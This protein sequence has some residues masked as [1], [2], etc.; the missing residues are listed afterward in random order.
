[1]N[2]RNDAARLIDEDD[3]ARCGYCG[4]HAD[5]HTYGTPEGAKRG[6][7]PCVGCTGGIC[8]RPAASAA[9]ADTVD[10]ADHAEGAARGAIRCGTGVPLEL[11]EPGD[12]A[13][14]EEF[15]RFLETS[16][17]ADQAAE[18]G[19]LTPR[20]EPGDRCVVVLQG[21]YYSC[22]VHKLAWRT[23]NAPPDGCQ[24]P[25]DGEPGDFE[26]K[27]A[28]LPSPPVP[29]P[30]VVA[31]TTEPDGGMVPVRVTDTPL[32]VTVVEGGQV[33]G[34]TLSL[35]DGLPAA[36]AR[37]HGSAADAT[38]AAKAD[39]TLPDDPRWPEGTAPYDKFQAH[40]SLTLKTWR[41]TGFAGREVEEVAIDRWMIERIEAAIVSPYAAAVGLIEGALGGEGT[42]DERLAE[43]RVILASLEDVVRRRK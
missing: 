31:W 6:E 14:V 24:S 2:E 33:V 4:H 8:W 20:G 3:P 32:H 22:H 23:S 17:Q 34:E 9:D 15:T 10:L 30:G 35:P 43:V 5:V 40:L 26:A 21:G 25:D 37:R 19:P 11:L 12:R 16:Y 41:E 7:V 18:A 29:K 42:A 1:M 27:L 28:A 36:Y 13:A 39:P 38:V